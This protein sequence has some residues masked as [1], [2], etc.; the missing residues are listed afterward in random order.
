MNQKNNRQPLQDILANTFMSKN[1]HT[2]K[3]RQHYM[4]EH[5][6]SK[7]RGGVDSSNNET[8]DSDENMVS[9]FEERVF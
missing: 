1:G 6:P 3:S 7:T 5:A 8:K 4:G 9:P 2:T